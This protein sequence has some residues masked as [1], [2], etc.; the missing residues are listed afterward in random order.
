MRCLRSQATDNTSRASDRR[1]W[2]GEGTSRVVEK[3]RAL[4]E[5]KG[6]Q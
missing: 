6:C 5:A 4:Q 1:S 3:A 2:T